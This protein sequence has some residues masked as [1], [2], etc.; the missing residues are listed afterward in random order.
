MNSDLLSLDPR[1]PDHWQR[2]AFPMVWKQVPLGID[3]TLTATT[4]SNRG[5]RALEVRVW[6]VVKTVAAGGQAVFNHG[7]GGAGP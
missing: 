5:D 1:L 3:I 4:V 6:G 7:S 2:L